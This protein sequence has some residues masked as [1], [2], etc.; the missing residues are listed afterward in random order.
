MQYDDLLLKDKI[1]LRKIK[2]LFEKKACVRNVNYIHGKETQLEA[3][4]DIIK[5]MMKYDAEK[6]FSILKN[7]GD[8]YNVILELYKKCNLKNTYKWMLPYYMYRMWWVELEVCDLKEFIEIYY[9]E[10]PFEITVV[11]ICNKTVFHI[12]EQEGSAMD[13]YVKNYL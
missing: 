8:Y 12:E 6:S 10:T 13:I 1:A 5:Q 4:D 7:D 2:I 3:Y 9:N 11:D